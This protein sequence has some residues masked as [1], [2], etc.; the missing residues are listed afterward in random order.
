M[1]G[2]SQMLATETMQALKYA[3]NATGEFY[4]NNNNWAWVMLTFKPTFYSK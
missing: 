4:K 3:D 2:Y 1:A